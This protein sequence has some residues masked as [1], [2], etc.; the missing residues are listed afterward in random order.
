M[1]L[2]PQIDIIREEKLKTVRDNIRLITYISLG[3]NMSKT[4]SKKT[5]LKAIRGK[6]QL[7]K[8]GTS[9]YH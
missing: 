9:K 4:Q 2:E 1:H 8:T 6:D 3:V 7:T 5:T